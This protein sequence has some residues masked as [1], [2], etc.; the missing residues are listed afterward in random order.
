MPIIIEVTA[1][2]D[3]CGIK[4]EV[5]SGNISGKAGIIRWGDETPL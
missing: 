3:R 5:G 4:W 2:C 1:I